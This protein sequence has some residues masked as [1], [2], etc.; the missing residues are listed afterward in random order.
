MTGGW[1]LF[2]LPVVTFVLVP[3]LE[4]VFKGSTDNLSASESTERQKDSMF[5]YLLYGMVFLHVCIILS[6]L[7]LLSQNHFV[8]TDLV[9]AIFTVGICC[10]VFGI[11]IGHELGHRSN[12]LDQRLAKLM[13]LTSLY[14]HFFIEHNRSHHARV[15]THEDPASSR[16]NEIVYLFW[17]RSICMSWISA[18]EIEKKRLRR[19]SFWQ[20]LVQNEMLHMQLIQVGLLL[21]LFLLTNL[22][23]V[24]SFIG[25]AFI[26]VLLLETVNYIEHYGLQRE[27]KPNGRYERVRPHHSWNSNHAIGRMLL[28]ELSR[29]SDHHAYPG[30]KYPALRHFDDSPQFPAGYPAMILLALCPPL[31]FAIMNPHLES[32][33]LRLNGQ[34]LEKVSA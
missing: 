7:Y 18:W 10:G 29:H 5:D 3:S 4:L 13:L 26:G 27:K 17:V 8:G 20:G 25:A 16:K 24:L 2:I 15:S 14:M 34:Q 31:W 1:T 32:E 12:P 33:L 23:V 28:F 21:G 9:G 22:T 30:R 11:N 6:F 19:K